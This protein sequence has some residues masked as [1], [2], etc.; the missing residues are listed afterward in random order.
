MD[1]RVHLPLTILRNT[2]SQDA[3]I[4]LERRKHPEEQDQLAP[5]PT[6]SPNHW[7]AQEE[8]DGHCIIFAYA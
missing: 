3:D 6:L 4:L 7:P 1:E 5:L 8:V 2:S